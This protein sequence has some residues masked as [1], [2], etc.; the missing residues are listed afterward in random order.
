MPS[1]PRVPTQHSWAAVELDTAEATASPDNCAASDKEPLDRWGGPRLPRGGTSITTRVNAS[2]HT[3]LQI[4]STSRAPT[5][6]NQQ[7]EQN[8]EE[9]VLWWLSHYQ[10]HAEACAPYKTS[11][12]KCI[13]QMANGEGGCSASFFHISIA[14]TF[15]GAKGPFKC[16]WLD[17]LRLLFMDCLW[18]RGLAVQQSTSGVHFWSDFECQTE[19][20]Q[21]R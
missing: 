3:R 11:F 13:V 9:A 5:C 18:P 19:G 20:K 8:K 1:T 2:S 7:S 6:Y 10:W 12:C 16:I 4:K 15:S 17:I 14:C 21:F